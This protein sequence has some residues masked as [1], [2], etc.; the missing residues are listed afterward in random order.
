[1]TNFLDS[2]GVETALEL[3]PDQIRECFK[4]AFSSNIPQMSPKSLVVSGMGGS[5]NA[6]KILQGLFESELTI[7][8]EVYNDYGLPA[9]VNADTLIVANSYSGNT[10]ETLSAIEVAK[11]LVA[12]F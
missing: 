3:F 4:Q 6:G 1:M 12:K 7:P 9:W 2:L 10:E 8:F 5:S 11:K